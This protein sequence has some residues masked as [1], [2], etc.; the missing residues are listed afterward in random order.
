MIRKVFFILANNL[1]SIFSRKKILMIIFIFSMLNYMIP[2]SCNCNNLNEIIE[3]IFRGPNSLLEMPIELLK[4]CFFQFFLL[5]I[6]L[7][8]INK[9]FNLRNILTILKIGSRKLWINNLILSIF[10]A[11]LLYFILGGIVISLLNINILS[12]YIIWERLI[13]VILLLTITSFVPCLIGLI[14]IY[15]SKSEAITFTIIFMLSLFSIGLG[16]INV[17][18][19]KWFPFNQGI[20]IKH[21][22]SNFS[23]GWSYIYS[24][25]L[26]SVLY[27]VIIIS[28]RNIDLNIYLKD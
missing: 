19:D 11:C 27:L 23:F 28:Q 6:V 26:I 22:S 25:V 12:N 17:K 9:E 18:L 24:M 21:Y 5:Y 14:L 7:D 20:L 8:F 4:W 15:L 10:I 1:M 3:N 16:S 2:P 13:K